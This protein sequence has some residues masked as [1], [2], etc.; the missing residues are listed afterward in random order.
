MR[1]VCLTWQ[2]WSVL[3]LAVKRASLRAS[4]EGLG[5]GRTAPQC[6][7]VGR[8]SDRASVWAWQ[9][10]QLGHETNPQACLYGTQLL[11]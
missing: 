5:R 6:T 10:G 4:G 8:S 9:E 11:P 7:V 3:A 1:G 2:K